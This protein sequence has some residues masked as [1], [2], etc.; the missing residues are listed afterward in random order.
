M[1]VCRTIVGS[2]GTLTCHY[3]GGHVF[4][5]CFPLGRGAPL[6]P[7]PNLAVGTRRV[8]SEVWVGGGPPYLWEQG[9]LC[10]RY[11]WEGGPY[12]WEQGGLCLRYGE[13]EC[14]C[15]TAWTKCTGGPLSRLDYIS[16][17]KTVPN[18]RRSFSR[19][20]AVSRADHEGTPYT[21]RRETRP[22]GPGSA[23][24]VMDG[25]YCRAGALGVPG[26][27]APPPTTTPTPTPPP[28]PPPHPANITRIHQTSRIRMSYLY[29]YP[30]YLVSVCVTA[31]R[32]RT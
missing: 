27:P 14:G 8:V 28:P 4:T 7:C 25:H 15:H 20:Q 24:P 21:A 10:L 22:P 11:G 19:L 26:Q 12:L 29:T 6:Y 2:L 9:G 30:K 31:L 3:T 18:A 17:I 5:A 13:G 1:E 23:L 16:S 32:H